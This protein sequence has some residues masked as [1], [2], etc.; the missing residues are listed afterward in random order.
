MVKC[1]LHLE[2][3][4]EEVRKKIDSC[5]LH[6]SNQGRIILLLIKPGRKWNSFHVPLVNLN[7]TQKKEDFLASCAYNCKIDDVS[8]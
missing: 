3:I 1:L 2:A 6:Q 5:R 7:L 4:N 8:Q